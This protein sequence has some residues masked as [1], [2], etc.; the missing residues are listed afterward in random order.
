MDNVAFEERPILAKIFT[1]GS[2]RLEVNS[3]NS[4]IDC[5]LV[6]VEPINRKTHFFDIL[7]KMLDENKNVINL[8]K[9][10]SS[11]V[12]VMK[13]IFHGVQIDLTFC[14]FVKHKTP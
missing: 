6:V 10:E 13:M 12:P 7:Y 11:W 9:I 2:Y 1:Y 14:Q 8:I 5:V 4:D 3:P